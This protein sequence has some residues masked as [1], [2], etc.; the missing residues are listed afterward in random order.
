M[1]LEEEVKR[2]NM[3]V[4]YKTKKLVWKRDEGCCFY[5]G[6][7]LSWDS[8]TVDHV[9]PRSKGGSHRAWNLVLSCLS[10]NQAKGNS[11]PDKRYLD[12]ILRWKIAHEHKVS[13]E[14]AIA[15]ARLNNSPETIKELVQIR[16]EIYEIIMSRRPKTCSHLRLAA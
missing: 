5:C 12:I 9:I 1:F 2:F 6:A 14:K 16:D 4:G 10:C 8:K 11:D 13:V 15:I 7:Q 3:S